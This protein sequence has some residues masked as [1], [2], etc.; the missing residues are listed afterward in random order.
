MWLDVKEFMRHAI[1]L[2][3]TLYVAGCGHL[4]PSPTVQ[5]TTNAQQAWHA[6]FLRDHVALTTIGSTTQFSSD[7][8]TIGST[9]KLSGNLNIGDKL[10]VQDHHYETTYTL[11]NTD[12]N[13]ATFEYEC[14]FDHRSFGKNLVS[15]DMGSVTAALSK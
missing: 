2:I 12:T 9:A 10:I 14:T 3:I 8:L 11:R 15:I 1:V 4:Q 7:R 13:A 6:R 5:R